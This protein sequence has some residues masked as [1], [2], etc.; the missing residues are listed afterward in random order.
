MAEAPLGPRP[1]TGLRASPAGPARQ[2]QLQRV[3]TAPGLQLELRGTDD[4]LP[5]DCD[6]TLVKD[7]YVA[8]TALVG[9]REAEHVP[10][11][12]HIERQALRPTA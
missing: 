2:P 5:P 9:V 12:E 10:V 1:P 11:A 6:T 8:V 7:G 3:R 4:V